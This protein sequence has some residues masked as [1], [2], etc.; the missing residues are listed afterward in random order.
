MSEKFQH[1]LE[2]ER[3]KINQIIN[4]YFKKRIDEEEEPY[5]RKFQTY[6]YNFT[7]G[8]GRRILPICLVNTFF[9]LSSD[10]DISEYIEDVYNIS[11]C[12]E[13][14]HISSLVID[15]L[16]DHE[17]IRRGLPT[18]H[19]SILTLGKLENIDENIPQLEEKLT[20]YETA[21]A[22]YGG[23]LISLLGSRIILNSRF[24]TKRKYDALNIFLSGLEGMTRGH[25]LDEH[26]R[27]KHLEDISL[28]DFLILSSLKRGKQMETAVG[29]GALLANARKSQMEPLMQAMNKIGIIDQLIND[30]K[31]SFGDPTQKSIDSDIKSGQCT[32]LTVIAYQS[33]SK[34][35]KQILNAT[36]GNVKA[37]PEEIDKVRTIFKETGALDFVRMYSNSLKN[38]VYNLL[39][40]IYPGLKKEIMEFF[41]FL[42]GFITEI[43]AFEE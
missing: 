22:I 34:E 6:T 14:L 18:F 4:S 21:S 43:S 2:S 10:R 23:N 17:D 31:G 7:K 39:Q 1:F 11:I 8:P 12:I 20:E 24:E 41:N 32:I 37:Q 28:E 16:V 3:Q 35:Q 36:L 19:K 13:L 38:D 26:L 27:L 25:L 42:L 15:D 30:V 40:K 29:I 33:A 9:G 5:L